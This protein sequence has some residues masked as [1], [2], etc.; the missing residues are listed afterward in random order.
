MSAFDFD[1]FISY[2]HIDNE[3]LEPSRGG[4]ISRFHTSLNALL[5]MRLGKKARIWRDDKLQGNDVFAEEIVERFG[6]TALLLS[7][8]SPRYLKSHWCTR[9]ASE[10][11]DRAERSGGIVISN[12]ARVFKVLKNPVP[13]EEPLPPLM[14]SL[15]G[16]DFYTTVDGTPMELDALYGELYAQDY[17]R[18][19]NKLAYEIAQ[20]LEAF[21][22]QGNAAG[23]G[24]AVGG[25]VGGPN[26]M[27]G[28]DPA[29]RCIYLAE[30]SFDLKDERERLEAELMRLG[31]TILPD[32]QLP[33]DEVGYVAAVEALV[34]RADL[35]IH[36]V[37]AHAGAVPDG[38]SGRA[39]PVL[40][41]EIAARAGAS[42]PRRLIWLPDGTG[43][44]DPAQ[45]AFIDALRS[46]PEAQRG[47]D[48]IAGDRES[49]KR[50]LFAELARA[51]RP[52]P[53][54]AAS[55]APGEPG[56]VHLLCTEADR[57][58]TLP[59]RRL[60]KSRGLEV[61]LP[62]FEGDAASVRAANQGMLARCATV[63]LWYGQGDEAWKRTVDGELRKLA[64]LRSDGRVPPVHTCLA[65]PATSDKED[66]LDMD[67]PGLVDLRGGLDEARLLAVL[68]LPA[69]ATSPEPA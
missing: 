16:Y 49:L 67:E 30:C 37:G 52:A 42:G 14:R 45:Q 7:V 63:L 26:P 58:P 8:L 2:A 24:G 64:A 41:N 46:D 53:D 36:P 32:R 68:D 11:C 15:L 35:S 19:V 61:T 18:K 66:L 60:L 29:G 54:R 22:A 57:K 69:E 43:S 51:E 40:Q 34:A 10:F 33:R 48:L 47:A 65:A 27:A 39:V 31:H 4:W 17:N 59:L 3:P 12:K 9:E 23:A 28:A 21:E 5:S 6:S 20:L 38:P 62:A 50:A 44:S 1:L 13:S 55:A 25:A 56:M